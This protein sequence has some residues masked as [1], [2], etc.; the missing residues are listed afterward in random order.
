MFPLL[1][2]SQKLAGAEGQDRASLLKYSWETGSGGKASIECFPCIEISR[3]LQ[4]RL[5][6]LPLLTCSSLGSY[7]CLGV[8]STHMALYFSSFLC[9]FVL[10]ASIHRFYLESI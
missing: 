6:N 2:D 10:F 5:W 8:S 7:S 1:K 4:D 3:G 9:L